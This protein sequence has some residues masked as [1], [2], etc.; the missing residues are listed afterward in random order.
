MRTARDHNSGARAKALGATTLRPTLKTW[1]RTHCKRGHAYTTLN[2]YTYVSKGK[3][4]RACRSCKSIGDRQRYWT[5]PARR[6]ALKAQ[7][8]ERYDSM[9]RTKE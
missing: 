1:K 3:T 7:A 4:L 2:T 6:E 9:R 8:K 5:N